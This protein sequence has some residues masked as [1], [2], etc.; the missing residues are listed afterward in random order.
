V[1]AG[2]R[3][4]ERGDL[5][6]S[7]IEKKVSSDHTCPCIYT[8]NNNATIHVRIN[9]TFQAICLFIMLSVLEGA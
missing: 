2:A 9:A 1:T 5:K 7:T 4:R 6:T 8:S 3:A